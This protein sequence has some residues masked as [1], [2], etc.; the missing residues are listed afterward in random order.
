[1]RDGEG[2]MGGGGKLVGMLAELGPGSRE[3]EGLADLYYFSL[4][5]SLAL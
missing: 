1:M 5:M 3:G 4:Y 2:G